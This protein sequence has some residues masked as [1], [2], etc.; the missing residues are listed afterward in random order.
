MNRHCKKVNNY[1]TQWSIIETRLGLCIFS[2]A[3]HVN[4]QH[5]LTTH[6]MWEIPGSTLYQHW[7]YSYRAWWETTGFTL[8]GYSL[9]AFD[10]GKI[11]P[12]VSF[13]RNITLF[14]RIYLEIYVHAPARAKHEWVWHYIHNTVSFHWSILLFTTGQWNIYMLITYGLTSGGAFKPDSCGAHDNHII[15]RV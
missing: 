11:L 3:R 10:W 1:K 14:T 8:I 12:R 9:H 4:Q 2:A 15:D 7:N 13:L 6:H 5:L